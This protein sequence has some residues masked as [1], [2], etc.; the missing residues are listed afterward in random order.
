MRGRPTCPTEQEKNSVEATG[1]SPP[2]FISTRKGWVLDRPLIRPGF[3]GPP[4]PRGEGFG[5]GSFPFRLQH[6]PPPARPAGGRA[7]TGVGYR[8]AGQS[9]KE[10]GPPQGPPQLE[11]VGP[12]R[13]NLFLPGVLSP[14][15]LQRKSGSPPESAGPPGALRP[16]VASEPPTPRVRTTVMPLVWLAG[17]EFRSLLTRLKDAGTFCVPW[18]HGNLSQRVYKRQFHKYHSFFLTILLLFAT[19]NMKILSLENVK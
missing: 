7:V 17:F 18:L 14:D 11:K 2:F 10:G 13:K 4:S 3:A 9:K 16:K 19:I 1:G 8:A 12:G 5:G 6:P 15:F